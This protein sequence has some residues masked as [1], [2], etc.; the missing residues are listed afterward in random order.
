MDLFGVLNVNK[1]QGWTSFQVVALVRRLTGVRRVGHS[2][3][4]DPA[5]TGVLP[6]FVGQAT[7]LVAYLMEA[8]KAYRAQVQLGVATDTYD[9]EGVPTFQGDP[10]GLTS[11]D[12]QAVLASLTGRIRQTPPAFSALKY[13]GQPLYRYARAGQA[14]PVS[15]EREVVVH[16][17]EVVELHS[18]FLTLEVECGKGTYIR[19]LAHD[20]GQRLGCGAH[21]R[22]LVR[23]RVGPFTLEQSRSVDHL[24]RAFSEGWWPEVMYQ[25]DVALAHW[26]A[27]VL[28]E[29]SEGALRM[30]RALPLGPPPAEPLTAARG[31]LCRAYSWDG[32]LIGVLRY[33]GQGGLWQPA[34]VLSPPRMWAI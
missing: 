5:A 3:T 11:A 20:L 25:P 22:S 2:G 8:S 18:P 13:R 24:R 6:V 32:H 29:E 27:A 16:R 31:D 28:S 4:L 33:A 14:V 12:V 23:T 7:R 1:P 34:K 21:L 15:K 19:S 17:I 26:P 10:S 30:G 9:A